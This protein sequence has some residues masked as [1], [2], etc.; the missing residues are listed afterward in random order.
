[1]LSVNPIGGAKEKEY[2]V[3]RRIFHR[4]GITLTFDPKTLVT[5]SKPL[6]QK[7]P[8]G[9][10]SFRFNKGERIYGKEKISFGRLMSDGRFTI[11]CLQRVTFVAALIAVI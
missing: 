2:R 1:M 11:W 3:W 5:A 10:M 4:I 7:S 8:V 6:T 9:E